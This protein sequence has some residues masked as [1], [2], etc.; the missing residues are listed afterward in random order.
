LAAALTIGLAA[1]AAA[2]YVADGLRRS[3]DPSEWLA[4]QASDSLR[5]LSWPRFDSLLASSARVPPSPG[6]PDEA[7]AQLLFAKSW[8][9]G[10][11][12]SFIAVDSALLASLPAALPPC[13]GGSR[14]WRDTAGGTMPAAEPVTP[15]L[16]VWRRLAH[17]APV[18][19]LAGLRTGAKGIAVIYPIF[20]ERLAGYLQTMGRLACLNATTAASAFARGDTALAL[21]RLRENIAVG[22]YLARSP[23]GTE[24]WLGHE[25]LKDVTRA[26]AAIAGRAHDEA[27][28]RES[29]ALRDALERVSADAR[30]LSRVWPALFANLD[31][32]AGL[33]VMGDASFAPAR[34]VDG[35]Y[36]GI[37]AGSCLNPREI[38]FGVDPR[39]IAL[40]RRGIAAL[41]DIPRAED[42]VA[43]SAVPRLAQWIAEPQAIL[44]GLGVRIPL[45]SRVFVGLGLGRFA[46]RLG[47]CGT[48]PNLW[49]AE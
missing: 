44:A 20:D 16:G 5:P 15:W 48:V 49:V 23:W 45:W 12:P 19:N 31:E 39:R 10:P 34:R 43:K 35:A 13:L 25:V 11:L 24:R 40:M 18:P 46:W 17:S 38:L 2:V 29:A 27:L 4:S 3:A 21:E 1:A 7:A 42:V 41:A 32:P 8:Q 28:A 22:R 37:V 36:T 26:F 6:P 30:A 47:L 14:L 33:R 9:R